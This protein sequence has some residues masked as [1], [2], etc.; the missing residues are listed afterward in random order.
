MVGDAHVLRVRKTPRPRK[1]ERAKESERW[2]GKP[3][4]TQTQ[5]QTRPLGRQTS[6]SLVLP[7]WGGIRPPELLLLEDA[8]AVG[9]RFV[10]W[11]AHHTNQPSVARVRTP[12]PERDVGGHGNTRNIASTQPT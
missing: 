2:G 12:P 11:V 8:P 5:T 1:D 4:H 9:P 6:F 3:R 7:S 10:A